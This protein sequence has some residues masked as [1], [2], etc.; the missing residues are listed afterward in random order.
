MHSKVGKNNNGKQVWWVGG[1]LPGLQLNSL[2]CP[3]G[4]LRKVEG[5]RWGQRG[6]AG[7]WRGREKVTSGIWALRWGDREPRGGEGRKWIPSLL[8]DGP[9]AWGIHSGY[10]VKFSVVREVK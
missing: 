8:C 1:G 7:R 6:D 4:L 3:K 10:L 2:T 9:L 5:K